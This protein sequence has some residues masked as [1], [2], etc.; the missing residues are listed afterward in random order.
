[1]RKYGENM[2]KKSGLGQEASLLSKYFFKD[3]QS[4]GNLIYESKRLWVN[5][6]DQYMVEAYSPTRTEMYT[7]SKLLGARHG[8]G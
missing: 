5:L 4:I 6:A 2:A 1:M 8:V 3:R 7:L